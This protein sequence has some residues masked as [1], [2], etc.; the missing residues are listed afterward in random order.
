MDSPHSSS[1]TLTSPEVQMHVLEQL[2]Q[3]L[4]EP[5]GEMARKQTL[6]FPKLNTY[7]G[8]EMPGKGEVTFEVWRYEVRSL[9]ASHEE[10][11]VR[12]AMIRS[13]REPAATVLRGLPT[14]ATVKEILRCMEQRCDPTVDA[15][16]ML[17]E[18]NNMT[19]GSKESAAAY[20]TRLEAALHRICAKH[21]NEIGENRAQVMLKRGCYQ[22]LR[23]GLK[24]SLRYLYDNPTKTYEDL[25]EKVI[26]ID[27]EKSGRPSVVSKSGIIDKEPQTGN[28]VSQEMHNSVQDLIKVLTAALQANKKKVP[29]EKGKI[30]N[31]QAGA[32]CAQ[33]APSQ[34]NTQVKSRVDRATARCNKCT[35]I[36]HFARECPSSKYLNSIRGVDQA[37]PPKPRLPGPKPKCSTIRAED[38]GSRPACPSPRA[39]GSTTVGNH[40]SLGGGQGVKRRKKG[41]EV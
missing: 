24:E 10:S 33:L 15:H 20:I 17:K 35:R 32:G 39:G 6:A 27:G 28:I 12:E 3:V 11:V 16:V 9:C 18:F 4:R 26:Q 25:V 7:S 30:P 21:P 38:A 34:G 40:R 41:E 22:G 31:K 14:N 13:L 19:Q 36:G 29:P 8:T 2:V 1:K 23:D 37:T 5:R